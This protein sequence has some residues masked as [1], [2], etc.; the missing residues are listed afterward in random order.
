MSLR[1]LDR[2][3]FFLADAVSFGGGVAMVFFSIGDF[4]MFGEMALLR[5]DPVLMGDLRPEMLGIGIR[6]PWEKKNT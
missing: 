6:S 3:S 5:N 1:L 2:G 4:L